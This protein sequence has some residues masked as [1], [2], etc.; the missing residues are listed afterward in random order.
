M[1][2]V[3]ILMVLF[4]L[5]GCGVISD[6]DESN[7]KKTQEKIISD[8]NKLVEAG[9]ILISN[10]VRVSNYHNLFQLALEIDPDNK[11]ALFYSSFSGMLMSMEGIVARGEELIGGPEE[12]NNIKNEMETNGTPQGITDFIFNKKSDASLI[13]SFQEIKRFI[14]VDVVNAFDAAIVSMG[15]IDGEVTL[16]ISVSKEKVDDIENNC[17]SLSENV[18][19]YVNC[20]LEVGEEYEIS[21][22]S[23]TLDAVDIK[24][25]TAGLRAYS[26]IGKIVT[27]Y[28]IEG[29]KDLGD[30]ISASGITT[31]KQAHDILIKYENFLTLEDDHKLGDVVDSLKSIVEI[32]MDLES[33]NN[34]FCDTS[35][36]ESNLISDTICFEDG[37]RDEMQSILDSMSGPQSVV[38]GKNGAGGEVSIMINVPAYLSNPVQDLK[39]FSPNSFDGNGKGSFTGNHILLPDVNGLFPNGDLEAKLDVL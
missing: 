29:L 30:E 14:Q 31:D 17:Q 10:S 7:G 18:S 33:L 22:K 5:I 39:D 2:I 38:L 27:A 21:P 35:S 36:R 8:V 23:V 6:E 19:K 24:I 25:L 9:E 11:K 4:L 3:T 26:I 15:K 34:Q 20:I 16:V 28:S 32:G 37:V 13:S 1:K 12:L